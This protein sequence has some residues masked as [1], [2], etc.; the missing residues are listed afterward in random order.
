[1]H[2]TRGNAVPSWLVRLLMQVLLIA[3]AASSAMIVSDLTT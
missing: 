1:V 2:D 3:I